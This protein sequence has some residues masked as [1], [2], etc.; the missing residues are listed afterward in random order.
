LEVGRSRPLGQQTDDLEAIVGGGRVIVDPVAREEFASDLSFASPVCPSLVVR[1]GNADEVQQ[2]VAWANAT[3]TPLVP[4]S[5]GPPHF[6]GDTVPSTAG[7]VIVDLSGMK[8]IIK[9]DA[10]NRVALVEPGV[11]YAELQPA[12]REAGLAAYLPL[13]PR[14]TKSVVTS[15][16]EREPITQPVYH[17]DSLDPLLCAE[18]VLGT[19]DRLRTGEAAGPDTIEEQWEIGKAQLNP[20]GPGQYD[21]NRLISGAQGTIGLVTWAS[22]KCRPLAELNRA[23]FVAS[24]TLEPLVDLSYRL[25]RERL[26]SHLFIVNALNLACLTAVESTD[27]RR[28]SAEL[29]AWVLMVTFESSGDLAADKLAYQEADFRDVL[30]SYGLTSFQEL[31]GAQAET[32]HAAL[33]E[34]CAEPYWKLRHKGRVQ[35]V[36][37]QSTLDRAASFVDAVNAS[38]DIGGFPRQDIGVYLQLLVQGTSCHC[39]FDFYYDPADQAA[40]EAVRTVAL[41]SSEELSKAG[42][43]FSRP[44]APWTELA[45]ARASATGLLQRKLKSIFDPNNIL[46]PGKLCF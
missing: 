21:Q 6:R 12:L 7:S 5:S 38:A 36:F 15:I 20:F 45:Y 24:E 26:G 23:L 41:L 31:H 29:P 46:N 25:V 3:G 30:S 43:F 35:D 34:P 18:M 37:F 13:L 9:I 10:V 22:M 28:L 4:I 16:L 44:Y 14:A 27:I 8:R 11:T 2:I 42:A 33:G 32:L 1:P 19:G 39:E 40:V 17:W